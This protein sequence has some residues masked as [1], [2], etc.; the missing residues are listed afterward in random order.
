LTTALPDASF[1]ESWFAA[2][3]EAL[4]KST[5]AALESVGHVVTAAR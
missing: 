4:L 1:N 3:T 5:H 2:P